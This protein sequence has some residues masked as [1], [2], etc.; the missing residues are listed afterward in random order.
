MT[1]PILPEKHVRLNETFLGLGALVISQLDQPL[2]LDD[3]WDR[4][5][6]LKTRKKAIPERITFEDLILTIDLLYLMKAVEM[7]ESGEVNKCG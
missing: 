7:N 6:D 5:R 2:T 1:L 3:I 4:F